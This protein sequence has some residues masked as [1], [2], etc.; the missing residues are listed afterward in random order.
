[1]NEMRSLYRNKLLSFTVEAKPDKA[2][3][4]GYDFNAREDLI[5]TYT[6]KEIELNEKLDRERKNSKQS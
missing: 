6:E 3:R 1:M 2:S 4:L 5:R